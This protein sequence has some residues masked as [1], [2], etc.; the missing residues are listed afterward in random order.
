MFHLPVSQPDDL[1]DGFDYLKAEN[2]DEIMRQLE[3]DDP[4]LTVIAWPC[5]PWGSWARFQL[6]RGG[7]GAENVARKREEA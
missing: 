6:G 2:Q 7:V 1:L 4:W 5:G 3:R